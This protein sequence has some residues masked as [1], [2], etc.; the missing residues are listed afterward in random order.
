MS[1]HTRVAVR[2]VERRG[3]FTKRGRVTIYPVWRVEG[4][5]ES[6]YPCNASVAVRKLKAREKRRKFGKRGV[7][8]DHDCLHRRLGPHAFRQAFRRDRRE[9]DR[10]RGE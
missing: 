6:G 3:R 5:G 10:A 2:S 7:G 8:S 1:L 4:K 9:P